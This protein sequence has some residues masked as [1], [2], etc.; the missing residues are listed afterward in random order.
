MDS[1]LN[2]DR[3]G[4]KEAGDLDIEVSEDSSALITYMQGPIFLLETRRKIAW[5]N[6]ASLD[7]GFLD[8]VGLAPD[9]FDFRNAAV[10][11][12]VGGLVETAF[13]RGGEARRLSLDR[14]SSTWD[15]IALRKGFWQEL[16]GSSVQ[17]FRLSPVE[18]RL[19]D[20][21]VRGRTVRQASLELNISYHTARKYLQA[22]FVKTGTRRQT[23]LVARLRERR[24]GSA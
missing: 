15:V 19:V 24:P 5:R 11:L 23:E 3:Q 21:I 22:I 18:R 14:N 7:H 13:A 6:R 16:P 8:A 4:V 2:F 9:G 17:E 10:D 1:D 12:A 20:C